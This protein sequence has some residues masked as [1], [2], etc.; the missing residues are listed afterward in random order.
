MSFINSEDEFLSDSSGQLDLLSVKH[1]LQSVPDEI[2]NQ[3]TT[4]R[5]ASG[6]AHQTTNPEEPAWVLDHSQ[7]RPTDRENRQRVLA[8]LSEDED[9]DSIIDLV[10]Q[11]PNLEDTQNTAND[12]TEENGISGLN[13]VQKRPRS[14]KVSHTPKNSLPLMM[15]PKINDSLLLLQS[16]DESL[17][18][19]GDIG[20]VGRVK[21]AQDGI[22]FDIKGVVYRVSSHATNT[23][24]VVQMGED[25][26]RVT[27]VMDEVLTLHMDRTL[28]ASD[29]IIINGNLGDHTEEESLV[30]E[31]GRNDEQLGG[32]KRNMESSSAGVR[33]TILGSK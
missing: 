13:A 26:A 31:D 3:A 17:D 8:S 14:Q 23:A 24:C 27:S 30:R 25:E 20:A 5:R 15:A 32:G 1:N 33:G 16:S 7:S 28:F 2:L 10:S 4:S 11:E 12:V 18:L 9:D 21:V 22:F 6:K 29:E 19:S